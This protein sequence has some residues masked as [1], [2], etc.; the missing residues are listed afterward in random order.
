MAPVQQPTRAADPEPTQPH[1]AIAGWQPRQTGRH[2][3][4]CGGCGHA[5]S[6]F[7]NFCAHCGQQRRL[8]R[9]ARRAAARRERLRE[10]GERHQ[11]A[12]A[13][14]HFEAA[15]RHMARARAAMRLVETPEREEEEEGEEEEE[16]E[17]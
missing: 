3:H 10:I 8:A 11:L 5:L 13:R 2:D 1:M 7:S 15:E 9:S 12:V 16:E 17:E 6:G 14:R 4:Y